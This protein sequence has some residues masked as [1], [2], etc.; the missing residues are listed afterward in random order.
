MSLQAIFAVIERKISDMVV[1]QVIQ[2]QQ[3]IIAVAVEAERQYRKQKMSNTA[4][5]SFDLPFAPVILL[6]FKRVVKLVYDVVPPSLVTT[7]LLVRT[8]EMNI[9]VLI[10][11]VSE[12]GAAKAE[13]DALQFSRIPF[14]PLLWKECLTDLVDISFFLAMEKKSRP[15]TKK[16]ISY[17]EPV[18]EVPADV[19]PKKPIRVSPSLPIF[20]LMRLLN[21]PISEVREGILLGSINALSRIISSSK[22]NVSIRADVSK[23]LELTLAPGSVD[24]NS[25]DAPVEF[26]L[27][28][29]RRCLVER[30]P[31]IL[32]V[33]M[34]LLAR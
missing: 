2:L 25:Q 21:H 18:E 12:R 30:E 6:T 16:I 7:E 9:A 15:A 23:Y 10:A 26:I 13:A 1:P 33:T 29:L 24:E 19:S 14:T 31:P 27:A 4:S 32:E 17:G 5:N 11:G 3:A 20:A 34:Q 8:C 28:L 22:P